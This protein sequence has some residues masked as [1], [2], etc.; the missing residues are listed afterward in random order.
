MDYLAL[1]RT[2]ALKLGN[3]DDE[4]H[5]AAVSGVMRAWLEQRDE[6][7]ERFVSATKGALKAGNFSSLK[8]LIKEYESNHEPSR[9]QRMV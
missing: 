2:K 1:A 7:L 6:E 9:N 4:M 8:R 5:W 3:S